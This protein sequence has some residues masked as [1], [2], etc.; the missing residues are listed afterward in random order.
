MLFVS[1]CCLFVCV[2][3][4]DSR[5]SQHDIRDTSPDNYGSLGR[6]QRYVVAHKTPIS[7]SVLTICLRNS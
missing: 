7:Y 5:G 1:Y 6:K 2:G 4:L 3:A